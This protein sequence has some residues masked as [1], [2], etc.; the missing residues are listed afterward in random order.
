MNLKA[1]KTRELK[2]I[3]RECHSSINVSECFGVNDVAILDMGIAELQRRGIETDITEKISF[4][5]G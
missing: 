1:M 4:S 2:R 5:R 3:V